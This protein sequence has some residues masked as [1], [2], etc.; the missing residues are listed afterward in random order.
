[1]G[2]KRKPR[3][4]LVCRRERETMDFS[5]RRRKGTGT[6]KGVAAPSEKGGYQGRFC[7]RKVKGVIAFH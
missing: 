2:K 4:G 6:K 3:L 7:C 1:M 5:A